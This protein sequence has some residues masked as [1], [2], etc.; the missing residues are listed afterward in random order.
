MFDTMYLIITDPAVKPLSQVEV[1]SFQ[2]PAKR[3]NKTTQMPTVH[4]TIVNVF[5]S[6]FLPHNGHNNKN[7]SQLVR[8]LFSG[9]SFF[10]SPAAGDFEEAESS[11]TGCEFGKGKGFYLSKKICFGVIYI[12]NVIICV[13]VLGSTGGASLR[14]HRLQ[15]GAAASLWGG[16]RHHVGRTGRKT[17]AFH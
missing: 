4:E 8:C 6:N 16:A 1:V 9:W 13:C 17:S 11:A 3:Q 5:T 10:P 15:K 14:H 7:T 12:Y 2:D